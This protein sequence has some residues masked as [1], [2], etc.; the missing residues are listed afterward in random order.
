M[1]GNEE[2]GDPVQPPEPVLIRGIMRKLRVFAGGDRP[3]V[4][5]VVLHT[6]SNHF[7]ELGRVLR[8]AIYGQVNYGIMLQSRPSDDGVYFRTDPHFQVAIKVYGKNRLRQMQG[9]T[10]ENPIYEM[11]T[12]QFI[13][14]LYIWFLSLL[15][16]TSL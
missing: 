2:I 13:G 4:E 7:Y 9:R 12:M 8:E 1:L 16:F 6:E 15:M 5:K 14:Q 10:Q 11:S 3:P